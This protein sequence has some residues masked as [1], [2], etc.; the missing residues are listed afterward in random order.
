MK[1]EQH[2]QQINQTENSK[3]S[4]RESDRGRVWTN[5]VKKKNEIDFSAL[6]ASGYNRYNTIQQH[7]F[8]LDGNEKPHKQTIDELIHSLKHI[9]ESAIDSQKSG[10]SVKV[11]L[12]IKNLGLISIEAALTNNTIGFS[13]HCSKNASQVLTKHIFN[14]SKKIYS[15]TGYIGCFRILS[16]NKLYRTGTFKQS[17]RQPK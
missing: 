13:L 3:D 17:E 16:S 15:S 6:L 10:S 5:R 7:Y 11:Q 14:I 12:C 2:Q 8:A 9:A 1:I 4:N